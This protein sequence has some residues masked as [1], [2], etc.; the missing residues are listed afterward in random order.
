MGGSSKEEEEVLPVMDLCWDQ[1]FAA[2]VCTV[3]SGAPP[4]MDSVRPQSRLLLRAAAGQ[5]L[6]NQDTVSQLCA[7]ASVSVGYTD[8]QPS[9]AAW[10]F[11]V[12]KY[13][14]RWTKGSG[15]SQLPVEG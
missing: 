6:G 12:N 1:A 14:P 3:W 11:T 10:S 7:R 5:S 15:A 13:L 9:G 4:Y 8:T 2:L